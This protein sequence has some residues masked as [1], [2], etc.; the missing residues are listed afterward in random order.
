M[1]LDCKK[2]VDITIAGELKSI[3]A[4]SALHRESQPC[5]GKSPRLARVRASFS[6]SRGSEADMT[7]PDGGDINTGGGTGCIEP[8]GGG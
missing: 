4:R 2:D 6:A 1:N 5:S 7:Y 3:I 8:G